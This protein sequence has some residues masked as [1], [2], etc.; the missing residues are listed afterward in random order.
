MTFDLS[1]SLI[2]SIIF[3]MEDQTSVR[4]LDALEGKLVVVKEGG[5]ES[6][7]HVKADNDRYYSLP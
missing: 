4:L 1:P 7:E 2:S 6:S 5:K 3:S